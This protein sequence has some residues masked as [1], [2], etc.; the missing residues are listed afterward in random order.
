MSYVPPVVGSSRGR[1]AASVTTTD[2]E[3]GEEAEAA[4]DGGEEVEDAE[5][6][7]EGGSV[8]RAARE[9]EAGV[10]DGE[11]AEEAEDAAE[12]AAEHAEVAQAA[13]AARAA[14]VRQARDARA[15]ARSR[16]GGGGG[17]GEEMTT[18]NCSDG[19]AVAME[20][21]VCMCAPI[22][23]VCVPC[24]HACM[25]RK[26]SR[27]LRRCPLCRTLVTRRQKLFL[28]TE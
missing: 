24:G 26:C 28:A 23:V 1:A 15:R 11:G 5:V 25:C 14:E 13:R 6:E 17:E 27:R 19:T 7:E 8:A 3:G 10:D 12:D 18:L 16:N 22:Q 4:N 21:L 9:G 2:V 20:C